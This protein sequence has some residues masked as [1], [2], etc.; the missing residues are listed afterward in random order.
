MDR[1]P[2]QRTKQQNA[3]LLYS[4]NLTICGSM[5]YFFPHSESQMKNIETVLSLKISKE[6]GS[7]MIARWKRGKVT[8]AYYFAC[9]AH[10]L[11]AVSCSTNEIVSF[12]LKTCAGSLVGGC[13]H[14]LRVYNHDALMRLPRAPAGRP[15]CPP[16]AS[17]HESSTHDS[18]RPPLPDLA[19]DDAELT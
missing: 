8:A 14:A 19:G 13:H 9:S 2:I 5:R 15:P 18:A 3:V 16:T 17:L 1:S 11:C 10:L 7:L 12:D 6:N 4:E